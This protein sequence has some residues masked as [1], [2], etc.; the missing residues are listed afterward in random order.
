MISRPVSKITDPDTLARMAEEFAEQLPEDALSP[1]EVQGYLLTRKKEP[2]RALEEV[3][4]WRDGVL[5]G[6]RRGKKL[7]GAQ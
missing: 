3:V 4:G 1:A 7:V 2:Q 6:K 5:E